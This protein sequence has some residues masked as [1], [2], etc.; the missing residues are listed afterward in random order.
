MKVLLVLFFIFSFNYV[1]NANDKININFKDLKISDLI[2]ITSKV[3]NKNILFTDEIE[4]TADFIPN[5]E[6]SKN[7]LIRILDLVLEEKGY[8]LVSEKDILRVVKSSMLKK[9]NLII[10]LKN[11]N[12]SD[13]KKSLD[14]ISL[15]MMNN[16][17]EK[18]VIIENGYSNSLILIG[19][20]KNLE[21]LSKH[22]KSIDISSLS[23][24]KEIRIFPLKNVEATNVIK[25]LDEIINKR[26]FINSA[27]KPLFSLDIESNS[28]IIMGL[29]DE[30]SSIDSLI[31]ELDKE[32]TQVYVQARIIEVNDDLVNQIG[33]SYGIFGAR[34]SSN[35]LSSFSSSLNNGEI[36]SLFIDG[37]IIPDLT[38]G[39]A[40][41]ASLNLLKQNGALDIVSEP[42]ILAI[43]NKESSIYVGETISIKVS[44]SVTDGG[45]IKENYEREDVGLTLKVKPRISNDTK[46]TLE[47]ETILEGVKTTQTISGNADTSKKR[48]KTTTILNNGESVI[49]GGLIENKIESTNQKVPILGDI[50][51]FGELFKNTVNNTEKNNLVVIVTPYLIPKTKDI[52]FVRNKLSEL[53]NLEDKYLAD[54][55]VRLKEESLKKKIDAKNREKKIIALTEK[56]EKLENTDNKTTKDDSQTEHEKRVAEILGY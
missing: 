47:I 50:P 35:V 22:I 37:L 16:Q 3:I 8:S 39:L 43:N 42:S 28:I 52:T 54:S 34:A 46:V 49:I 29:P 15:T 45:T 21:I 10:K 31:K 9:E 18:T 40:L 23:R 19:Q 13:A 48:I 30:I 12:A 25:I 5:K 27:D 44:S 6:V 32:K 11:I 20:K 24:K 38:S 7:E 33:V 51:L 41:G 56:L 26:E 53:K 14:L 36:P 55:L 17:E 2:K 4:G 1:I